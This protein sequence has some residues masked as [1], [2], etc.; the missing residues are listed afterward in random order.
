MKIQDFLCHEGLDADLNQLICGLTAACNQIREKIL[1]GDV[2]LAGSTNIYGEEQKALDLQA[3]AIFVDYCKKSNLVGVVGSEELTDEL[4][5]GDGEYAV[6]FDP[7]DGSSLID[8]N[9]SVGSIVSIYK[10]KTFRNTSG[11]DMVAA[12]FAVYG[13]R[14]TMMITFGKGTHE[15][16]LNNE[17][18][19]I[20][21]NQ[22][23]QIA[24]SGKIFAPGNLGIC[25][26]VE[27]YHQL[28]HYWLE[29]NYKLRYSGGMVPDINQIISKG[30]G[31]FIYPGGPDEPC[32]KLRLLFE[33]RPMAF[34]VEEAGGACSDGKM[35]LLD[36]Q[37][38]SLEEKSPIFIGSQNEVARA[39]DFFSA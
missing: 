1:A 30:K 15:F 31:I 19:W 34:I 23:L 26:A 10:A 35:A 28:L 5:V 27:G 36:K 14:T 11:R 13:P 3:D 33:C 38:N 7:L 8:V 20:L 21:K 17:S 25:L 16:E 18:E 12:F 37:L 9:L 2:G 24:R 6:C 22:N 4:D 32:G 39:V 29:N